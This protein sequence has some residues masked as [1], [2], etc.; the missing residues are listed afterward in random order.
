LAGLYITNK[1]HRIRQ[2]GTKLIFNGKMALVLS[3]NDLFCLKHEVFF[4]RYFY[5]FDR[6]LF[7]Y[8]ESGLLFQFTNQVIQK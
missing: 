6:E 5:D 1:C 8:Q 7:A 3:T 2:N 4:V